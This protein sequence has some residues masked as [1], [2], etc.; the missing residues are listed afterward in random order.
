M[1]LKSVYFR[2]KPFTKA[3]ALSFP[4]ARLSKCTVTHF[5]S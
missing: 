5:Q 1:N 4:A 2:N 3:E